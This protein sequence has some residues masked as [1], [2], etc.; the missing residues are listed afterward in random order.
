MSGRHQKEN[1]MSWW[2]QTLRRCMRRLIWPCWID[3]CVLLW[4]TT[5]Q[6]TWQQRTTSWSTTRYVSLYF[7]HFAD[8][9]PLSVESFGLQKGRHDFY[10]L[11]SV[12][13]PAAG[14]LQH[15]VTTLAENGSPYFLLLTYA[16][17]CAVAPLCSKLEP[18]WYVLK[19]C[20]NIVNCNLAL[21]TA[22]APEV[23]SFS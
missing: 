1:A 7:L 11:S 15:T 20:I 4:I 5:L 22:K 21:L 23:T 8:D 16:L 17:N 9:W 6:I 12:H 13:I 2:S 3:F 18:C 10:S 14:D 19:C